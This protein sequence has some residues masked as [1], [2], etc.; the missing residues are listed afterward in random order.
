MG[1]KELKGN[2]RESRAEAQ[3]ALLGKRLH[4]TRT[5]ALASRMRV[6]GSSLIAVDGLA[7]QCNK[8]RTLKEGVAKEMHERRRGER[9]R[10]TNRRPE[11]HREHCSFTELATCTSYPASNPTQSLRDSPSSNG[12]TVNTPYLHVRPCGTHL[13][14]SVESPSAPV[15]SCRPK[16]TACKSKELLLGKAGCQYSNQ[17]SFRQADILIYN[18]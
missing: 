13:S 16:V 17:F 3:L 9:G 4:V 14:G 5:A 15:S 6:Y 18:H 10:R 11:A 1:T 2:Q 12:D 7:E 8:E